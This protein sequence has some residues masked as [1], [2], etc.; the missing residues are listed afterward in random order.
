M[1]R[2]AFYISCHGLGHAMRMKEVMARLLDEEPRAALF[3]VG[4]FPPWVFREPP[5]VPVAVRALRCDVGC[6][7]ADSLRLDV[8]RTIRENESFHAGIDGLVRREA[9][10]LRE[11]GIDLVVGDIPPLAFLAAEAAGLE[12]IAVG[13]FSWDW[14]YGE[15]A[16]AEPRFE[17]VVRAVREAYGLADLLL[18]LPFHGGMDA[19]RNVR[20]IPLIARAAS[21]PREE[22]RGRLG[23]SPGETRKVVFVSMGGHANDGIVED[24]DASDFG[25]YLFVSY[26]PVSR[27][28]RHLVIPADRSGIPHPDIVRA[29]DCVVS[30]P[31]Y[32]TTAECI[33]NRTPMAYTSR[34][35]FREYPV[36]EEAV[37]RSCPSVLIPRDD[38]HA[39]RW[40]PHLDALFDRLPG[41][42]WPAIDTGG[43]AAA[44]RAILARAR[45][46]RP[47]SGGRGCSP[48]PGPPASPSG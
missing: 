23:V 12:G 28:M 19:F 21:A 8:A 9:A 4:T 10:F 40:R 43:A 11:E 38:F 30:K 39:G 46:R 45:T 37:R 24:S 25:D 47:L 36:M 48:R 22:V 13:N 26:F 20:D 31:G 33:A 34:D 14:I 3:A 5:R 35:R 1:P 15:Y 16:E 27:R 44:A 41:F 29:S 2:I 6:V 42:A 7:Q 18:R 17:P 32:C